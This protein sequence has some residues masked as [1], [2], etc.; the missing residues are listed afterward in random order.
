MAVLILVR[1]KQEIAVLIP[2]SLIRV[3]TILTL[4]VVHRQPRY[5]QP[6]FLKLFKEWPIEVK[7]TTIVQSI[8]L[9]TPKTIR[10]VHR[11]RP[12]RSKHAHNAFLAEPT[13]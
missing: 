13:G 8:P 12:V 7:I 9:V 10:A 2:N 1:G 6:Q 4:L 3:F 5:L 11:I